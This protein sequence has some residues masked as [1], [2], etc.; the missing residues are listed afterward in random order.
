MTRHQLT[1]AGLGPGAEALITR[2]TW[3]RITAA[4]SIRL[5]TRIHP[6]AAA[7][8]AAGIA[9]ESYDDFYNAAE[10]FDTLYERIA[11]DLLTRD[12]GEDILYLVPGSPFVAERTVQILRERTA[13]ANVPVEIL[14]AVSF[15]E[16]LFAALGIDPV[17]GLSIADA[18]DEDLI[19]EGPR[20]DMIVTQ[21]YSCE[22]ASNLKLLLMEHL[23]D[24][25]EVCVLHHLS[26]P[27]EQILRMPLFEI[28][29]QADIDH[30][31]TL[32]IPYAPDFW[33][34]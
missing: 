21:L 18:L 13:Q 11:D 16:P 34:K 32:F 12:R 5:R 6:S 30:L 24:T 8:D 33:E 31:T 20:Q 4:R 22:I 28:D 3:D 25:H 14:P 17:R 19:A 2:E 9:Y 27:D 7:L 1:V 29:R 15:L 10:N 23:A 26:L